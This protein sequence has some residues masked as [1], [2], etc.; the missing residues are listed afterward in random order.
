MTFVPESDDWV[1]TKSLSALQGPTVEGNFVST[2]RRL[3]ANNN[4]ITPIQWGSWQTTWSGR[5]GFTRQVTTGKGKRRR[6]RTQRFTRVRTDQ[7]R[8]G[9]CYKITPVIEQQSLGSRVV[10]VEHIQNMRSRNVEFAAQKMAQDCFYAFFDGVNVAKYITPKLLEVT[11]NPVD[12]SDT[13]STPFQV[14]ETV[15]G[16]T[17]KCTL[18]SWNPTI[19]IRN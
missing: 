7:T 6:T 19:S 9:I 15:K 10:S 11:K 16:L 14:G 2:S 8:T 13:N 17:S 12:D 18:V 1:D 4:G 5:I 3:N